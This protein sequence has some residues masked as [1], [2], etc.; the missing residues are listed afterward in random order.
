MALLRRATKVAA[1][2]VSLTAAGA[3][4]F[5]QRC[6]ALCEPCE[7]SYVECA[8]QIDAPEICVP[9]ADEPE[10]TPEPRSL[11]TVEP[12]VQE[13]WDISLDESIHYGLSN[14]RVLNDVG[15][16]LLRTPDA[17]QTNL[18][19][20]LVQMDPRFGIEAAL[21]AFD[22]QLNVTSN[23]EKNDR[24][25]NN[26]FAAGG[27]T[28]RDFQQDLYVNRTELVKRSATGST[29]T[30]RN[31]TE[32]DANNA[33]ANLFPSAWQTYYEGEIR[34]PLLQGA[35][36]RFNRI[37][38]PNATPGLY[39]GVVIARVNSDI[40]QADFE[41]GVREYLSNLENAYW[42]LYY[43]YRDLDAK[44]AARDRALATWRKYQAL[45]QTDSTQGYRE[46]QA[47][48]QYYRFEQDV[49]NALTGR[50]LEGT[51]VYNGS[52]GGTFRATPGVY[53]AERRLRL[54]MGIPATDARVM[55][56]KNE[57]SLV[58]VVHVWD[59]ARAEALQRRP[60]LHRQRY[61]VQR[62]ELELA[63][64]RNFLKPKLD[65]VGRYRF[66]GFGDDLAFNNGASGDPVLGNAYDV[67]GT[68]DF[69]EWMV[70]FELNA[71]LGY[72][73]AHSAVAHAEFRIAKERALL[74]E[75]E[76]QVIHDLSNA[77]AE[78]D[79]AYEIAKL[80]YDRR[81][82]AQEN[83]AGLQTL[84]D[85]GRNVSLDTLLDAQRRLLDADTQFHQA[86]VDY[87]LSL[88]NVALEKGSLLDYH[89]ILSTDEA[90]LVEN[91]LQSGAVSVAASEA[92]TA[93]Q[94]ET[95]APIDA[96]P[97]DT[98]ATEPEADISEA[99]TGFISVADVNDA[100]EMPEAV[101]P[102]VEEKLLPDEVPAP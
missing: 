100:E 95:P 63:A 80:A 90:S 3:G 97:I 40:A 69:Q 10:C 99:S 57:P 65:A 98:A 16:V 21:S 79:R 73:R 29:M 1:L 47:R 31:V 68:A 84:E 85:Q 52:P 83:L 50:R 81:T 44:I 102:A 2:A 27:L 89:N 61:R 14:S 67:L 41:V 33:P 13:Y 96:E 78:V 20:V 45:A 101:E 58:Q 59:S 54:L 66:R 5:A 19:P 70:G 91:T 53:L 72:R 86:M 28:A 51:K 43:A 42:D 30:L 64:A 38:G 11:R 25:I 94:I 17:V 32:Y 7:P 87:Q 62:A 8:Q 88:K 18:S 39:N 76:R 93:A 56:P 35:G 82:A 55:R 23:L 75:Q 9:V 36:T 26:L 37:A 22:A 49:K 15:G 48:D 71:P 77:V 4:C 34:Q 60:E 92:D 74:H 24:L 46:A 12:G 6:G